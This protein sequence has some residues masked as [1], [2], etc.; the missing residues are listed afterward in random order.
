MRVSVKDLLRRVINGS[1]CVNISGIL[2]AGGSDDVML[3]S[4]L[5][6]QHQPQFVAG[7]FG[8]KCRCL[9]PPPFYS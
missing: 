6:C 4:P 3:I 7:I 1:I 8:L 5:N 9:R 2:T